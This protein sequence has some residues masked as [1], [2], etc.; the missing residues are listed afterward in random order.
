MKKPRS[1]MLHSTKSAFNLCLQPC[2]LPRYNNGLF[3]KKRNKGRGREDM[4]LPVVLK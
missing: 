2:R 3:K 4:E 1:M